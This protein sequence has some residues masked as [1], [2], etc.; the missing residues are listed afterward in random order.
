MMVG[1]R[2]LVDLG[3][4]GPRDVKAGAPHSQVREHLSPPLAFAP[5]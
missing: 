4:S 2:S 1:R 5:P 3:A